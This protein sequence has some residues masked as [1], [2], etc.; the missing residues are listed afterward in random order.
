MSRAGTSVYLNGRT[1]GLIIR[2]ATST[3]AQISNTETWLNGK[4]KIY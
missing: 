3:A 4:A 1:Y 2:G